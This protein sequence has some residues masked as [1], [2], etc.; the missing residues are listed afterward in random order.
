MSAFLHRLRALLIKEWLQIMRDKSI[1][2]A[3]FITPIL[4]LCIYGYGMNMDIKPVRVTLVVSEADPLYDEVRAVF[5]GSPYFA[6]SENRNIPQAQARLQAHQTDALLFVPSLR[7]VQQGEQFYAAINGSAALAAQL[8]LSYLQGAL[9]QIKLTPQ[10]QLRANINSRAWFN[11][12]NKSAFYLLPGQMVGIATLVCN[13][14]ASLAIAREC[15][16]GT[17]EALFAAQ[18]RLPELLLSK[19]LPYWLL[20]LAAVSLLIILMQVLFALPVRGS[21]G[22]LAATLALYCLGCCLFGLWLSALVQDQFLACEYAIILSFLPAILLSGAVFDLRTLP[23]GIAL[24]GSLLP[25]TY[26]VESIKIC[27]LSG[28]NSDILWTN[29]A[30]ILGYCLIFLLLLSRTLIK[31]RRYGRKLS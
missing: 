29:L 18:V 7:Q 11:P 25:P 20:S 16:R 10:V 28:G 12:D 6:V 14:I 27:F 1:L 5:T 4:L 13:V 15:N 2:A 23:W 30:I 31:L 21:I 24:L 26:A 9:A 22:F 19:L 8:T 17:I 3:A